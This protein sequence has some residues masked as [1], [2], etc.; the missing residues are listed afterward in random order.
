M[1]LLFRSLRAILGPTLLSIGHANRIQRSANDVIAHARQVLHAASPHEHNGVLLQVVPHAW[2]IG[3]DFHAVGKTNTRYFAQCRVGFFRSRGIDTNADPALLRTTFE[4]WALG[5]ALCKTS[6]VS[7]QLIDRWHV[8]FPNWL[9]AQSR[10]IIMRREHAVK[11]GA[12]FSLASAR[13][14]LDF[15]LLLPNSDGLA[16]QYRRLPIGFRTN[17]IR[18]AILIEAGSG[19]NKSSHDYIFLQAQELIFLAVDRGFGQHACC[20][21]ERSRRNKAVRR[22]CSLRNTQEHRLAQGRLA[23]VVQNTLVFIFERET[24]HLTARQELRVSWILNSNLPQHLPNDYLDM[25]VVDRHPL[26]AIHVLDFV[27][28]ILL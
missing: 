11:Q 16:G 22:Q 19:R 10:R 1:K 3:C 25:L 24:T 17:D 20:L 12:V 2:N 23:A 14:A 27:D 15:L 4:R 18:I 6:S 7:H 21:L 9:F 26:Q 28:Q 13:T 5:L 8:K